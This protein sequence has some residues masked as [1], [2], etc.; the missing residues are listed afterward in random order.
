NPAA[1]LA[2][3]TFATT[4]HAGETAVHQEQLLHYRDWAF[5]CINAIAKR[6]AG[7]PIY[8]SIKRKL[9]GGKS[10]QDD[11][12]P[13][14]QHPFL[15]AIHAPNKLMTKFPL[16]FS[17]VAS[18]LL[19]G[20]SHWWF[21]DVAGEAEREIWPM[22]SSWIRP[23]TDLRDNY[24]I[25]PF[26]SGRETTVSADV[27]AYFGLPDPSNPFTAVSPLQSQANAV[28]ADNALQVAQ[29]RSFHNGL[30][31]K[32]AV[33]AGD[34]TD[35]GSKDSPLLTT[36]QRNVILDALRKMYQGPAKDGAAIIL[37][38]LIKDVRSISNKPNEMDFLQSGTQV[39]SRIFGAFQVNPIIV[40]EIAG[41]NR[42]QA[43]VAEESFVINVVNPLI[44]LINEVLTRW[45][46]PL[47]ARN[48]ERLVVWI[49][50]CRVKDHELNIKEYQLALQY[51]QITRNE[52]RTRLLGLPPVK[53]GNVFTLPLNVEVVDADD[54]PDDFNNDDTDDDGENPLEPD[55]GDGGGRKKKAPR[56]TKA[57]RFGN[58]W[59]R[60]HGKLE[61]KLSGRS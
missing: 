30:M 46:G 20:K 22:P 48:G 32:L 61:K 15:D 24:I 19:T 54:M 41:A 18:L 31:P 3:S 37:D 39:R 10:F 47:F 21:P 50:P 53:S 6:L 16:I 12:L 56:D 59:L 35:P 52:F 8:V 2:P 28:D 40:G 23:E 58:A 27:V 5:V 29:A 57:S 44:E 11:L 45:V 43:V 25:R 38:G 14:D 34:A 51:G 49:E 55:V 42:A 13:L 1:M 60:A 26:N 4:Y 33:I 17:T 9:R 36:D 7:Q